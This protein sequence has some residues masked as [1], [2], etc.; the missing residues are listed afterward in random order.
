[1]P[2]VMR[3]AVDLSPAA[4]IVSVLIGGSLAGFAGALLALP[5]AAAA[6]VVI[7][8]TFMRSRTGTPTTAPPPMAGS[9]GRGAEPEPSS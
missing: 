2:R 9:Q 3:K 1:V 8:E 6:K 5:L 7:R 4:V